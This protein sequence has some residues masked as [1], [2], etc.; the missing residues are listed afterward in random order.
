MMVD[1]A[2]YSINQL[3]KTPLAGLPHGTAQVATAELTLGLI[4][5]MS[6]V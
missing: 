5:F 2:N 3:N 6:A 1:A 4:R